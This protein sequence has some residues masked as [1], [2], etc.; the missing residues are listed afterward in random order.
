M[1][2]E[3]TQ[4]VTEIT[5]LTA[6]AELAGAQVGQPCLL[7]IH[8]DALQADADLN[9]LHGFLEDAPYLTALAAQQPSAA[10]AALFDLVIDPADTAGYAEKL[11]KDMSVFQA[12]EITH[13][14]VT[15]RRGSA[16][17]VLEAESR[18]F[19]RLIA[20]KTGGNTNA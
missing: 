11:F 19:Y 6:P 14:F 20:A 17:D 5:G 3:Q 4:F 2:I 12:R 8:G 13:C 1:K 10:L 16:A 9:E 18:A 15:A 7:I